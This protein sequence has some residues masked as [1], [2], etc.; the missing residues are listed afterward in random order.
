MKQIH[1]DNN[2]VDEMETIMD[3]MNEVGEFYTP[4]VE[5]MKMNLLYKLKLLIIL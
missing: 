3:N 5:G 4:I 1:E 2:V